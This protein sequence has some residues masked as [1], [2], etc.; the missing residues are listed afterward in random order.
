M[1]FQKFDHETDVEDSASLDVHVIEKTDMACPG[2]LKTTKKCA[3]NRMSMTL[4]KARSLSRK[5]SGPGPVKG[6]FGC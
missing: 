4:V 3:Y 1:D 5:K 2:C 6:T